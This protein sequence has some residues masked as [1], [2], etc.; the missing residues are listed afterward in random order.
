MKRKEA[1]EYLKSV[2]GELTD[3]ETIVRASV[4]VLAAEEMIKD[5]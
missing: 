2:S 4:I 5:A 1:I 3:A